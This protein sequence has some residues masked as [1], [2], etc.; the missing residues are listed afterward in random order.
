MLLSEYTIPRTLF[1]SAITYFDEL[2]KRNEKNERATRSTYRDYLFHEFALK[3]R[4][5]IYGLIS[6]QVN[7]KMAGLDSQ[8]YILFYSVI[9]RRQNVVRISVTPP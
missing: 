2:E 5:S 9:T 6:T 1:N 4:V 8:R 3:C 7:L